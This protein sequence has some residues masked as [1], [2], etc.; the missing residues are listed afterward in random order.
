MNGGMT[1]M[2]QEI[3]FEDGGRVF[4]STMPIHLRRYYFEYMMQ[5][6][7][8]QER[9]YDI[10][11]VHIDFKNKFM[12]ESFME[13]KKYFDS[14]AEAEAFVFEEIGKLRTKIKDQEK[15]QEWYNFILNERRKK[16][17]DFRGTNGL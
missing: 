12:V 1:R 2:G 17:N 3:T 5:N 15:E 11:F 9:A 14:Y 4:A 10:S 16:K 13:D 6:G 8:K 7:I